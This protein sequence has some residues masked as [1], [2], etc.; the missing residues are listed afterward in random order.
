MLFSVFWLS[1][2]QK[3]KSKLFKTERPES[4]GD[5]RRWIHVRKKPRQE[6]G[7]CNISYVI[8]SEKC[9]F[10]LNFKALYRVFD[11]ILKRWQ[12]LWSRQRTGK[13]V[14]CDLHA[15]NWKRKFLGRICPGACPPGKI[16]KSGPLRVDFQHSGAKIRVFEQKIDIIKFCCFWR[17]R[18]GGGGNFQRKL[19]GK[20][21][22]NSQRISPAASSYWEPCL[23]G[24]A[25]LVFLWGAQKLVWCSTKAWIHCLRNSNTLKS[26]TYFETRNI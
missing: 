19:G 21:M 1:C 14:P 5:E 23:Y 6:S 8:Y 2:H 4:S 22:W 18:G 13:N 17:G 26:H 24:D 25:M 3:L 16:L 12:K 10:C 20:L 7:L 15:L 11:K 9:M